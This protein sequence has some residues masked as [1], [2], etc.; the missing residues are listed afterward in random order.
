MDECFR[1]EASCTVLYAYA[2]GF[3][4]LNIILKWL[5]V[6]LRE[7]SN[8]ASSGFLLFKQ[9]FLT[10]CFYKYKLAATPRQSATSFVTGTSAFLDVFPLSYS[11]YE[12]EEGHDMQGQ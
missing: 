3:V 2:S 11:V 10:L 6:L 8:D 7:N 9:C 5:G 1:D 4:M 12:T